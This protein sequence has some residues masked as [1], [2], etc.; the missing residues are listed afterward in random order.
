MNLT[1]WSV[2][3]PHYFHCSLKKKKFKVKKFKLYSFA[4]MAGKIWIVN[5]RPGAT[6]II[7]SVDVTQFYRRTLLSP[8]F[9]P[10]L[11]RFT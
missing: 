6:G 5:L 3:F 8:Q 4:F 7:L 1:W 9:S 10:N 11:H 2:G